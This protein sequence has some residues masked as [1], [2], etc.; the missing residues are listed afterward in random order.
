ME[1][2]SIVEA[3]RLSLARAGLLKPAWTDMP[4]R[5]GKGVRA[6]REAALAIIGRFGYLQLDTVS[7]TGARSHVLVLLSRLDG[8]DPSLGEELLAP[9]EPLFEYW[10]HEA[11][12]MPL[13][14]YPAFEFRRQEMRLH[15]WWGDVIGAH[16]DLA[17]R[18]MRRIED[19]GPLR[20]LD[21]EGKS[22]NGW[23]QLKEAK[24]VATALWSCGRLAIRERR[25]FQRSYDLTE[26]VIPQELRESSMSLEDSL[27]TL[28]LRA[29]AG[30][31]WAT[32]G[33]IAATWRLRNRRQEIA[34]ALDELVAAGE[35]VPCQIDSGDRSPGKGWIR[36]VDLELADRLRRVRPR[37]DRGVLLSP[38]DPVLWDRSRVA[39]LFGFD[40]V[41]E[42]FKPAAQRVYGY[43][44]MPVL[45]GDRLV[46]RVDLKCERK[47]CRLKVLS[48]HYETEPGPA[49]LSND[50][51]ATRTAVERYADSLGLS[52]VDS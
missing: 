2:L 26:R 19:E 33:T 37:R 34:K 28:I 16:P 27:R 32:T 11:S 36:P 21:M 13:E 7:V 39:R 24:K 44:C 42:I 17:E 43:Y 45:A 49:T 50:R 15:P 52:V 8:F 1:A 47:Q 46:A 3:R 12:W 22:G 30:H 31:G 35:V 23:W 6:A 51:E 14:L 10:G 25:S 4:S 20:S 40:Q 5:A 29:L 38:F 9:G 18:I 48:M 41:L